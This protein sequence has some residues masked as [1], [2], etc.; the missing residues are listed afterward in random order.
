MKFLEYRNI[1]LRKYIQA[2]FVLLSLYIGWQF[3]S[4]YRFL[5]SSG[6]SGS[7]VRPPGVEA[8]IPLSGLVGLRSWLGTGFFD[9][10]HPAGVT[11][12]LAAFVVSFLFRK[13]FC[14]WI[15]PFGL[16][17]EMLSQVG[18][19]LFRKKIRM[20]RWLDIPL[21]SVKYV[22]LAF[23]VG[24]VF[25]MMSPDA[26]VSFVNSP[27]NKMSDIKM[28]EFFLNISMTG[29][30][31]FA[32]LIIMSVIIE[33]FWCRYLCPYGALLG[34]LGWL[35]P[36]RISRNEALCTGCGACDRA[37]PGKL[38][39]SSSKSILS[40]ECSSCL[41]C[42]E[43]CPSAGALRYHIPGIP[44]P[45]N[46]VLKKYG[47]HIAMLGVYILLIMIAKAAGHWETSVTNEDFRM[48]Y[49]MLD[50]Y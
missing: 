24:S 13:S 10:I 32:F 39:V 28:L 46:P 6:F 41:T 16:L 23:F 37:C 30:L 1:G 34:I 33:N 42:I 38:T 49:S 8:F 43:K 21:R 48:L 9:T 19:K 44:K 40:P 22:L 4:F 31:V 29:F 47:L 5:E 50:L 45:Q 20:P 12:L 14:S 36:A 25:L 15:C 3:L 26:A 17:E 18:F 2:F 27:Y 11:L 7:P 35:S